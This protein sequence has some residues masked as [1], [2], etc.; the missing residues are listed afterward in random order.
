[1]FLK[2]FKAPS[3]FLL[4][5]VGMMFFIN[6][7]IALFDIL[8][9]LI[10]CAFIM[11][12]LH[13]LSALVSDFDDAFKY[14]KYMIFASAIRLILAFASG[15]FDSVTM[16]SA[17]LVMGIA[18]LI[19][20]FMAFS[21]LVDGLYTLRIRYGGTE[22]EPSELRGMAIVFF[23]ARG[24]CSLLPYITSVLNKE[25]DTL[26]P[27]HIEETADFSGV[28][29]I[30]NII[31]TV[32][33]AVFFVITVINH[34]GK[35]SK[36]TELNEKIYTDIEEK[37]ALMPEFFEKRNLFFAL[38]LLAYSTLFLI[39]FLSGL[40]VGGRNFIPDIGF[41]LIVIW[42]I[43]ILKKQLDDYKG[44]LISGIVYT[45]MSTVSYF[46]YNAFLT[47]YYYTDF[48]D[49]I[50]LAFTPYITVIAV[51]LIETVTLAVFAVML[52]RYLMPIAIYYSIPDYTPE[53]TRLGKQTEKSRRIS[54]LATKVFGI[55]LTVIA[56]SGT[57][58]P[59]LFNLFDVGYDD[60]N[61]PYLL[62][63]I[64]LHIIFYAYSSTLFLRFKSGVAKRY[65]RPEDI[66]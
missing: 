28:L 59:T 3:P 19:I 42:A 35:L 25:D 49:I 61:F 36:N 23:A 37:K 65:E 60:I 39:D 47:K 38:T 16:L 12:G 43:L 58:L 9:D 1:M 27:G 64:V 32:V 62:A 15:Q 57:A 24:V 14:F 11:L 31:V 34:I 30:V 21:S 53:F 8:P 4:I 63:H 13:K 51:S 33:F 22:K 48:D 41:G 44:V 18:E 50:K 55:F 29:L 2:R 17:S 26:L 66:I 46:V 45:A 52:V 56:L 20:A 54:R 5:T 6:P 40:P 10:G 7:M